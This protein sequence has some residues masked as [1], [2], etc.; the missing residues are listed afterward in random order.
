MD[1]YQIKSLE[2]TA[3]IYKHLI[4][5]SLK[6]TD[7]YWRFL[8][9]SGGVGSGKSGA[10]ALLYNIPFEV[11]SR[12]NL[13]LTQDK[14]F[15]L[16]QTWMSILQAYKGNPPFDYEFDRVGQ[17]WMYHKNNPEIRYFVCNA[18]QKNDENR[19]ASLSGVGFVFADEAYIL[20]QLA[21]EEAIRRQRGVERPCTILFGNPQTPVHW[22]EKRFSQK[23]HPDTVVS[24]APKT[25]VE[26]FEPYRYR[27][28]R[29]STRDN[30]LMPDLGMYLE[31]LKTSDPGAI[32]RIVD[33]RPAYIKAGM[34]NPDWILSNQF[35]REDLEIRRLRV[36]ALHDP[37][38]G[39]GKG[40][41][42]ATSVWALKTDTMVLIDAFQTNELDFEGQAQLLEYV[43]K[44]YSPIEYIGVE[45]IASQKQLAITLEKRLPL[46]GVERVYSQM[47]K[48]KRAEIFRSMARNKKVGWLPALG[49]LAKY[50]IAPIARMKYSDLVQ[51]FVNFPPDEDSDG[52]GDFVDTCSYAAIYF[53]QNPGNRVEIQ[54]SEGLTFS[55]P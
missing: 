17:L 26:Y 12:L 41:Y 20:R 35:D 30:Y 47:S 24:K 31:T 34:I 39:E 1:G 53:R 8:L 9:L 51:A 7:D 43:E 2:L 18:S 19:L 33:G 48:E 45:S 27:T 23:Y 37:A 55:R 32:R 11:N 15:F 22:V 13:L 10:Q 49:T 14:G 21:V 52:H 40:D 5:Q 28:F 36:I 25:S 4:Q 46:S 50:P 29:M 44:A 38:G 16:A 6:K 3:Y 54:P 42:S